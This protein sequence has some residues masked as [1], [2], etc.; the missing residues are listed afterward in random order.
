MHPDDNFTDLMA[1]ARSGEPAAIRAFLSQF[2]PEVRMMVRARLPRK[3]RTQFDSSDFVQAVWQTFF[4]DLQQNRH[5]FVNTDHL[6]GFLAGVVRNK[7][8]EQHRRLT[9]TE[10]Y[11][12]AREERLYVRRGEREVVR[13][14][15]SPDPSPSETAQAGDFLEKLTAGRSPRDVE[16]ITLRYQGLTQAEIAA[17]TGVHERTVRRIIESAWSQLEDRP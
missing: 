16:V 1:R 11:N 3:L 14:V 5:E 6:K 9:R 10:K 17:Q 12:L 4:Y 15:L 7:V 13:E 2:E 8:R